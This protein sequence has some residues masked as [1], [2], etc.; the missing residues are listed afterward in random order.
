MA[1]V[2]LALS[3]LGVVQ[4]A[5]KV[6]GVAFAYFADVKDAPKQKTEILAQLSGLTTVLNAVLEHAGNGTR[7][8]ENLTINDGPLNTCIEVLE[9][10]QAMLQQKSGITGVY[11]RLTW[12][13]KEDKVSQYISRIQDLK[14]TLS[15]ALSVEQL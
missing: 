5:G 3:I 10:L 13:L 11:S 15:L 6:T 8:L 1:E 7:T 9:S 14:R 12:P 2:G 4:L